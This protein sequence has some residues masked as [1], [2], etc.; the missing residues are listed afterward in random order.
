ME[1]HFCKCPALDCPHNPNNPSGEDV[2]CEPCIKKILSLGEVPACVWF[3][4]E[5][6]LNSTSE[7]NMENFAKFFLKK[8]AEAMNKQ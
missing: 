5:E 6:G 4:V 8:K 1:K 3:N 2:G 7:F